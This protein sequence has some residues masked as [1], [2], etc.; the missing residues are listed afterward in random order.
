[1]ALC[2]FGAKCTSPKSD[3]RYCKKCGCTFHHVCAGKL[4]Q[5]D[6]MN[7]C[8]LCDEKQ[9]NILPQQKRSSH[10]QPVHTST[11]G[12]KYG[13]AFNIDDQQWEAIPG[14]SSSPPFRSALSSPPGHSSMTSRPQPRVVVKPPQLP[15]APPSAPLS[16]LS[17]PRDHDVDAPSH[18]TG[19]NAQLRPGRK[20][21]A[22]NMTEEEREY[23]LDLIEQAV[24]VNKQQFTK[25]VTVPLNQ[26]FHNNRDTRSLQKRFR[27]W[28]NTPKKSEHSNV[29]S[30]S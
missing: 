3:L 6:D 21:G 8:G 17:Q 18:L 30:F 2:V 28:A 12:L 19:T 13:G 7:R 26:R 15:S 24:P 4:T 23:F 1:M 5:S 11:R 29:L 25:E 20:L 27:N 9:S 10:D 22:R 16:P 14:P